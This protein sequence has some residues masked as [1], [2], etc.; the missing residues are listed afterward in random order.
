MY[1]CL[2]QKI[3]EFGISNLKNIQGFSIHPYQ[4]KGFIQKTNNT[5]R[6][7]IR[8][9]KQSSRSVKKRFRELQLNN[10]QNIFF[11][12]KITVD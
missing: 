9:L 7:K 3:V 2:G 11:I 1:S 8:T 5:K 6:Y 12:Y 4:L 10:Q